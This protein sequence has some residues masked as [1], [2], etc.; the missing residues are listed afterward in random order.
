MISFASDNNSGVH[1][2]VMEAIVKANSGHAYGYGEDSYTVSATAAV[3][4]QF[5]RPCTPL[6]VFNGT[7][8]NTMALQLL[9][10]PYHTIFCAETAHIALDECGAPGKATG[11]FIRTIATTN[12]KLTPQ[13]LKPYLVNFGVE[14]HS[15]PRAVYI[16]QCTEMG[17]IYTVDE[18]AELTAFAH[19]HS[20]VVH[21]DGARIANAS[22]ALGCS[23][24]QASF[25][26]DTLTLG[27]TKNG[28][29]GAECVVIFNPELAAEARYARKQSCQLA[30][31]MRYISCQFTAMLTGKLWLECASNA[32]NMA[33]RLYQVLAKMPDI[34]FTQKVQSNQL[35]FTMPRQKQQELAK[36]YHFYIWNEATCEVRLV[37]SFDTTPQDVDTLIA[38]IQ[39]I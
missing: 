18:L 37:T 10:R 29:M 11:C 33:Q 1:P 32:N 13:L 36:Q 39:S 22:A 30:S 17:T 38:A 8:S 15:Q 6:F 5:S 14:H 34:N 16:S 3:A 4:A 9:T 20:L 21:M 26:V 23:L 19:S 28:L 2:L 25:G 31:K 12:G 7:G 24:E 27:G 35:F